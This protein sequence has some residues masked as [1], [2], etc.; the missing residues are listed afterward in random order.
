MTA[1]RPALK[2]ELLL[3]TDAILLL[4]NLV[5]D[6]VFAP[7]AL[8]CCVDPIVV[9]NNS[10]YRSHLKSLGS[11]S[12]PLGRRSRLFIAY[13]RLAK[14]S[15]SQQR[16][17]TSFDSCNPASSRVSALDSD[18]NERGLALKPFR[19]A[20]AVLSASLASVLCSRVDCKHW[21]GPQQIGMAL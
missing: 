4:A 11:G 17:V 6:V 20:S 5:S 3:M 2:H 19:L 10:F 18:R 21:E 13:L 16:H 14:P 15:T 12:K 1:T 7:L 9:A 8:I